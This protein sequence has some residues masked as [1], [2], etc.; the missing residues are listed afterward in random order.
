MTD[1]HIYGEAVLEAGAAHV[2]YELKMLSWSVGAIKRFFDD[3]EWQLG[4]AAV[5]GVLLHA[6][7]LTEFLCPR[8]RKPGPKSTDVVSSDYSPTWM[9]SDKAV[10]ANWPLWE[11]RDLTDKHLAHITYQRINARAWPTD[12]I[13]EDI[14]R[15]FRLF[16][17][18]LPQHRQRWFRSQ[19]LSIL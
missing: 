16:L 7:I 5:E 2:A 18:S 10:I 19:L 1:G 17:D 9:L 8:A 3:P 14:L 4:S 13:A 12:Q 11:F 6:R 15:L